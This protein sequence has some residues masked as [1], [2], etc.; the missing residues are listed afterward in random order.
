MTTFLITGATGFIGCRV[1]ERLLEHGDR[2][3]VF[4]RDAEKA[5]A[6]YG[7][8][9]DV[10]VGDLCDVASLMSALSGV[11][12]LFL[13]NTGQDI[14][15][16]DAEAA[17]ASR[18]AGVKLLVKLS[19]MDSQLGVGTGH[20]HAQ[21]EAVIRASGV[22]FTFVEPAGFMSNAL[23][24]ATSIKNEGVVRACTGSGRIAFIHSDDIAAV[25]TNVL[26]TQKYDGESLPITG[27]E[28]LNYAEMTAKISTV[29][30]KSLM[31]EPITEEQARQR[32]I[33]N[34]MP[35]AEINAHLSLWHA[36]R[37]GRLATVTNNVESVLGRKPITFI[38]WAKENAS[39]F[40]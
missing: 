8:R 26:T 33:V 3:R 16:R 38:Q 10:V 35:T 31:F 13:V 32:L 28:A 36:I 11:D 40:R 39:A 4:V 24:W 5:R 25:I 6:R 22:N 27:P 20:W 2:P 18:D 30:G 23:L 29:I 14:P 37:E 19:S 15:T 34:G 9:V 7:N 1:V 12:V 21:G 17:K